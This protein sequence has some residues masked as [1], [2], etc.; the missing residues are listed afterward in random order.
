MTDFFTA[1]THFDHFRIIQYTNRPFKSI[2]QMQ[3]TII[4]KWNERVTDQD[5]VYILG[6]VWLSGESN[7]NRLQVIMRKLKGRK[8]LILG[9]HDQ[10]KPFTYVRF[11]IESVHTSLVYRDNYL[12]CHDPA[13]SNVVPNDWFVIHGHIHNLYK[14]C[15]NCM[16][17]GVDQW[18][19]Y[20]VS[21][22]Q[23][24]SDFWAYQ[25]ANKDSAE[26]LT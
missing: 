15:K 17:V 6:D 18:G 20:P 2:K 12:L 3:S 26:V 19:F 13:L 23:L 11:G 7:A 22:S 16:N 5:T 9:N 21:F 14:F 24:T 4:G 25:S 8:I 1:D 10:L